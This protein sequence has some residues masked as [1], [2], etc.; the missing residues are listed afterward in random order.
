[1]AAYLVAD[2]HIS[3]PVLFREF[4]EGVPATVEKYGGRYLVRGGKFEIAHGDWTPD[5]VIVAE[6]GSMD[7]ATAWYDSP[8]FEGL[9]P[10]LTR[11]SNSN[12]V[13]VEGV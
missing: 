3:D 13:F 8:E 1:M 11:S 7:Q 9:K 5:R 10:T 4:V 2:I 12:F 6:F